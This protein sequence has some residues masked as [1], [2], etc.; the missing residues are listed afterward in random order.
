ME[1]LSVARRDAVARNE[2][3]T[4]ALGRIAGRVLRRLRLHGGPTATEPLTDGI[5]L[6][7]TIAASLAYI[8]AAVTAA[9]QPYWMDEVLAVWTARQPDAR[10]VWEALRQGAEFSPPLYHLLLR[11]IVGFG[12]DDP[13]SLRLPSIAAIYVVALAAFALVRRRFARPIACLAL[14]VCLS[15]PL[16][17][18]A[19][20][21]RQ[22]AGVAACFALACA[23]WDGPPGR[24]VS[25]VRALGIA[26]L[27]S[28]AIGM[29][30]YA[31]LLAASLGLME[32]IWMLRRRRIRRRIILALLASAVSIL[33]WLPIM[34]A[35]SAYNHGDS[36]A[37][38]YYAR[39]TLERLLATAIELLRGDGTLPPAPL[40]A[41]AIALV[42]RILAGRP[43]ASARPD[44]SIVAFAACAVPLLIFAFSALVTGT[45]NTRYVIV[46]VLGVTL[47]IAQCVA[48]H[49][50]G[51]VVA[52]CLIAVMAG[53][54]LSGAEAPKRLLREDALDLVAHA[55]EGLPIATGDGLRFLEIYEGAGPAVAKRLVFLMVPD[56]GRS[57]DP[58]NDHQVRRWAQIDPRLPIR[59]IEGFLAENPEFLLF[60]DPTLP[61]MLPDDLRARGYVS[62]PIAGRAGMRLDSVR[63]PAGTGDVP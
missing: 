2:A 27:L 24:R 32:L 52:C 7:L 41:L 31:I 43:A 20:Q 58:T 40:A 51:S 13:V 14:V 11:T 5:A 8:W 15:G 17:S 30:F 57:P 34:Q 55:P 36:A 38:G 50:H 28:I 47:V 10:A 49:R 6:A 46:A 63:R 3:P 22:Y 9:H 39:P 61:D 54:I 42:A 59:P 29:H 33:L 19:V 23:L 44:L 25:G 18:Y 48:A 37:P 26:A 21:A 62:R 4:A 16:F 56:P 35:A 53:A 60:T 1:I 12:I 45:F